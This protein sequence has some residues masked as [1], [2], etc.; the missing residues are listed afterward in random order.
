MVV[1]LKGIKELYRLI[2][3]LLLVLVLYLFDILK[4]N[5]FIGFQKVQQEIKGE[6][7][8]FNLANKLFG[9]KMMLL[10]NDDLV[11]NSN[12]NNVYEYGSGYLVYQN[13]PY[14]ISDL[15]GSVVKITNNKLTVSTIDGF[16]IFSML[17]DVKVNLYEK[18]EVGTKL[19]LLFD[20]GDEYY[21]YFEE[22]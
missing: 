11:T 13:E 1:L 20:S 15:C 10:Y 22:N 18:V 7:E 17:K 2:I 3:L 9:D 16:V 8:I 19:A 21:Y 4:W 6:I 5:K 12:I 14:L